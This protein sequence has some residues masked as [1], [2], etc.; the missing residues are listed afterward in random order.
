MAACSAQEHDAKPLEGWYTSR[1]HSQE[2]SC[3]RGDCIVVDVQGREEE[4]SDQGEELAGYSM[5][6]T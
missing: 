2:G 1:D 3:E 4:Q 5:L 6:W